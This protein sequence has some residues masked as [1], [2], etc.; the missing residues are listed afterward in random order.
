MGVRVWVVGKP[1][2]VTLAGDLPHK[3]SISK[4]VAVFF[5][6]RNVYRSN[7]VCCIWHTSNAH[8]SARVVEASAHSAGLY[9][10]T[11]T[12]RC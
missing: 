6:C 12:T 7:R 9:S 10:G 11:R 5:T 8:S 2:H 1:F 3:H 4:K